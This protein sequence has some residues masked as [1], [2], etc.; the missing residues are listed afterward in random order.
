MKYDRIFSG[1]TMCKLLRGTRYYGNN[2]V[3]AYWYCLSV[4]FRTLSKEARTLKKAF[5]GGEGGPAKAGG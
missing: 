1:F 4:I 3:I 5:P 2:F